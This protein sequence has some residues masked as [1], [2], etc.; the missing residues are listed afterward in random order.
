MFLRLFLRTKD[1]FEAL[2]LLQFMSFVV[3]CLFWPYY[4]TLTWLGLS[5]RSTLY[6]NIK[7]SV[8]NHARWAKCKT[9]RNCRSISLQRRGGSYI[10]PDV[11]SDLIARHQ[12]RMAQSSTATSQL[13]RSSLPVRDRCTAQDAGKVRNQSPHGPHLSTKLEDLSDFHI[14]FRGWSFGVAL[15]IKSMG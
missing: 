13:P 9:S 5:K 3:S 10:F 8:P 7:N 11:F 6:S 4:L 12:L 1:V 15:T 14:P 2:L